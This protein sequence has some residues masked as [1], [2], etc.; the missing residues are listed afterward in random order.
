[1]GQYLR[2]DVQ[3]QFQVGEIFDDVYDEHCSKS[4]ISRRIVYGLKE[5]E[6]RHPRGTDDNLSKSITY[7]IE[8]VILIYFYF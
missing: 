4:F 3:A 5:V 2:A 7:I 6:Q 8:I 1:M